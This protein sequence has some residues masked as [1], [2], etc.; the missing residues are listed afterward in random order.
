[1]KRAPLYLLGTAA[2]VALGTVLSGCDQGPGPRKTPVD[3]SKMLD[4]AQE[5]SGAKIQGSSD[6]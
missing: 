3:A 4:N 2:L 1:M 6:G 5:S